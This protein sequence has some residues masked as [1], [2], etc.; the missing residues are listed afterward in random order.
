MGVTDDSVVDFGPVGYGVDKLTL[1][2]NISTPKFPFVIDHGR[3]GHEAFFMN[4]IGLGH[5]SSLLNAL[6]AT[7]QIASR[8]WSIF[9]GFTGATS[10]NQSDGT[11]VLGGYDAAKTSGDNITINMATAP[12]DIASCEA[13]GMIITVRAMQLKYP[14]G[15]LASLLPPSSSTTLRYCIIPNYDYIS[16]TN[17]VWQTFLAMTNT[18]VT[19]RSNSP[20]S[21][22][23]ML[24]SAD[25]AYVTVPSLGN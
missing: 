9:N 11:L 6:I 24:V 22:F 3:T 2:S 20:L 1:T 8:T 16:V 5:N 13:F 15:T 10:Q 14:N 21:W 7:G 18:V 19:G 17:D 4:S 12:A 23:Q 25:S